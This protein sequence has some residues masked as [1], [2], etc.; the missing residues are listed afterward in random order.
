MGLLIPLTG[1]LKLGILG[2]DMQNIFFLMLQF[3]FSVASRMLMAF[4]ITFISKGFL[5]QLVSLDRI[6]RALGAQNKSPLLC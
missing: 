5:T 4:Q 3:Y 2:R 6:N 1:S